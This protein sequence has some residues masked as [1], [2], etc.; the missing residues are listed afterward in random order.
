MD[1]VAGMWAL[2]VVSALVYR[3]DMLPPQTTMSLFDL[4]PP[5][6]VLVGFTINC[7][8]IPFIRHTYGTNF[9][10]ANGDGGD[11]GRIARGGGRAP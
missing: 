7:L 5:V 4:Y 10:S 11:Q 2:Q 8:C 6:L 9:D 1:V 3:W